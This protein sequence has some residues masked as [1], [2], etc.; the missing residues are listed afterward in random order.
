MYYSRKYAVDNLYFY[1]SITRSGFCFVWGESEGNRGANEIA[2][3][4]EK[5]VKDVDDLG[6]VKSRILYSDSCPGQKKNRIVLA[7]LHNTLQSQNLESIQMNYL[8]PDLTQ[9]FIAI[10]EFGNNSDELSAS[11]PHGNDC[12]QVRSLSQWLTICQL[13]RNEP[14]PYNV[15]GLIQ[16]HFESFEDLADKYFSGN[17][18][19]KI[20]KLRIATFKKS[21]FDTMK[22]KYT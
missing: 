13:V 22:I 12:W 16:K 10:T 21:A 14:R 15:E 7:A 9:Y 5:Y 17:L 3:I 4:L 18:T 19:G 8:L 1:E 2:T 6:S 20:R 11:W